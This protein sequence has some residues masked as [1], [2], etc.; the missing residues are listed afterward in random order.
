VAIARAIGAKHP[1]PAYRNPD[2]LAAALLGPRER[3]LLPD[4]PTDALDLD[5]ARAV[6]RLPD[7]Y[8]VGAHLVRTRHV[9]A[10]L[11]AALRGGARQVVVLG[12]GLDTRGYRFAARLGGVRFL[13]VDSPPTQAHKRARAAAV[14]GA[15]PAP[16]RY[17]PLD[18]AAGD[19]LGALR[20]H[21]YAEDAVT[22]FIWEGVTMYLPEEVVRGTLR[23]V[24]AHA[25][26][27]STLV[28]DYAPSAR[29]EIGDPDSL[30]ARWGEPWVFGFP[31]E[32]AAAAV[33]REGLAV[34]ADRSLPELATRYL[35]GTAGPPPPP[36]LPPLGR[37][38]PP[39]PPPPGPPTRNCV[40]R[41]P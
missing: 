10:T 22:L 21:G 30:P 20:A 40:A 8:N 9:D 39:R 6:A 16:V 31:G 3:A 27:G 24:R 28:F 19:L 32:S 35:L 25:A 17:V 13:E 33:E 34:V 37:P 38:P 1:D 41:V 5:Y 2:H 36:R 29:P 26:P 18:L 7:P 23:F 4:Y 15:P 14:L 12:A 11:A